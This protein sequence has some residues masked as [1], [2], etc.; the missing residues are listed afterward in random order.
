MEKLKQHS[1]ENGN[2]DS[3]IVN[4]DSTHTDISRMM[5]VQFINE[6]EYKLFGNIPIPSKNY[7]MDVQESDL[8]IL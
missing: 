8:F 7:S 5:D 3:Y 6:E 1:P 4:N 2:I